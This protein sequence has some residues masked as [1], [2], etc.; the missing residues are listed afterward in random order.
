MKFRSINDRHDDVCGICSW[1]K[2]DV[3]QKRGRGLGNISPSAEDPIPWSPPSC[4]LKSS[5]VEIVNKYPEKDVT[6]RNIS[7]GWV[8]E[9]GATRVLGTK[10]G[11]ASQN[12]WKLKKQQAF[13]KHVQE[14][15]RENHVPAKVSPLVNNLSTSMDSTINPQDINPNSSKSSSKTITRGD[16]SRKDMPPIITILPRHEK[17]DEGSGPHCNP[18]VINLDISQE[19]GKLGI[20][21]LV[22]TTFWKQIKNYWSWLKA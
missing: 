21:V 1:E 4:T 13:G 17:L 14:N 5:P 15:D 12:T 3:S 6:N 7:D 10:L 19:K 11:E 8:K 9:K 16:R 18:K 22:K 20:Q 2:P